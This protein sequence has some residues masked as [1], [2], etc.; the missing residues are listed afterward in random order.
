[1]IKLGTSAIATGVTIEA[2]KKA[3]ST[4]SGPV[5]IAA[6]VALVA[7]GS[8][9]KATASN[10]GKKSSSGGGGVSDYS[11]G[12]S[13]NY[14]SRGSSYSSSSGGG[15]GTY[16]FEIAGTKLI[17]VLKNTL[18]RNKALGGTTLAF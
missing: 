17:G 10:L 18:D 5:A 13:T 8:L 9:F 6:G 1:M 3:L 15:G 7:A 14:S 4:L 2:V 11:G 16:V 12:S